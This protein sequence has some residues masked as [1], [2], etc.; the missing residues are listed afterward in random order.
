MKKEWYCFVAECWSDDN[1]DNF[2]VRRTERS[3]KAAAKKAFVDAYNLANRLATS[4]HRYSLPI[5]F[6]NTG[7][8]L[9]DLMVIEDNN[10]WPDYPELDRNDFVWYLD[11]SF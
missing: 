9:E 2:E 1:S 4:D 5:L 8:G 7:T 11:S 10:L 6:Y 3:A